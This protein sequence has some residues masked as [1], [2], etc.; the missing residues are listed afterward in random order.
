[1]P[2]LSTSQLFEKGVLTPEEFVRAGDQ[3]VFRCPSWQWERGDASR[4]KDYLP[5]DKQFL[6]TRNVPSL[7]RASEYSLADEKEEDVQVDDDE[8]W[9]ATHLNHSSNIAEMKGAEPVS[10]MGEVSE[11]EDAPMASQPNAATSSTMIIQAVEHAALNEDIPDIAEFEDDDL[12]VTEQD[13]GTLSSSPA[14]PAAHE[15]DL[16]VNANVMLRA[17]EPVENIVRT[18]TYDLCI[19]YDKYYQTPRVLLTGFDERRQ[20]LSVDQIME[21][22]SA[23]HANKTVTIDPHPHTGVPVA[24]VHPCRHAEVMKK[25]M[26]RMAEAGKVMRVEQYLILFLKFFSSVIPTIEYDYTSSF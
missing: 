21:D 20:P 14:S 2:V 9:T 4:R 26:D 13:M 3:L 10:E 1:M 12:L 6:V 24:S 18:R 23:D 5:P 11:M 22:I 25:L 16:S 7:K 15:I 8:G 19:I 17:E